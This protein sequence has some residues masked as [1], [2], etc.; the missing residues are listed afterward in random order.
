MNETTHPDHT[1]HV[2]WPT[3]D[4]RLP[5]PNTSMLPGNE[6][7]S[8]AGVAM[9]QQAVQGAHDTIDR[10]ADSAEPAVRQLGEQVAAAE[11]TLHAKASQLRQARDDWTDSARTTVRGNPLA[12][13]AAVFVLGVVIARLTR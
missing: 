7:A 9:L 6:M 10:L 3:G 12:A 4:H 5:V 11:V 8:P 1:D 2:P 13:V